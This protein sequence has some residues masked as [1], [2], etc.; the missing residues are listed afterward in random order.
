M[1]STSC[2]FGRVSMSR[3]YSSRSRK[4]SGFFSQ[5]DRSARTCLHG[6]PSDG[7]VHSPSILDVSLTCVRYVPYLPSMRADSCFLKRSRCVISE[8]SMYSAAR[9]SW[10]VFRDLATGILHD[11]QFRVCGITCG[12]SRAPRRHDRTEQQ[13]R[14][15]QADVGRPPPTSREFSEIGGYSVG[16]RPGARHDNHRFATNDSNALTC[17]MGWTRHRRSL[18]LHGVDDGAIC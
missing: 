2:A 4:L 6:H 12:S 14:R 11:V 8:L 9:S 5:V 17:P 1:M 13:T 16:T 3:R 18:E 10:T 15:L 7:Q